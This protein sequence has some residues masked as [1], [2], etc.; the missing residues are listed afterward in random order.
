MFESFDS[1]VTAVGLAIGLG[2]FLGS[3]PFGLVLTR[4]A[5][6]GDIRN[7]GSGNIGATNVLR[8][9]NKAL[10]LL[11]LILDGG[12]RRRCGAGG[13][14]C[15]TGA[16]ADRRRRRG[17]RSP[18]S[19][20][21]RISGRKR[22][23]N[24]AGCARG[25]VL[26][27]RSCRGTNVAACR[28]RFPLFLIVRAGQYRAGTGLCLVLDGPGDRDCGGDTRDLCLDPAQAEHSAP[29]GRCRTENRQEQLTRVTGLRL[30]SPSA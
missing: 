7:I 4:L 22:R 30:T 29:F 19:G 5:G 18:V 10:A 21:A 1:G 24:D 11:T 26:A 8:T 16:C 2:Y 28:V 25:F 20:M 27:G 3:I 13:A 12:E 15:R 6:L 17:S 23:C 9:G 14:L